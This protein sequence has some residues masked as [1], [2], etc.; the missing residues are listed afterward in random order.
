MSAAS[1][2]KRPK[3]KQTLLLTVFLLL[4]ILAGV[5]YYGEPRL[6][7]DAR[8]KPGN[9]RKSSSWTLFIGV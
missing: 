1:G 2:K 4:V 8:D 3:L 7:I 6:R 5:P 9:Q